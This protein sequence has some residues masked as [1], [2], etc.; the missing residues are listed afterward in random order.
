MK[1]INNLT[2]AKQTLFETFSEWAE[3][4]FSENGENVDK[5]VCRQDAFQAFYEY[6]HPKNYTPK[7]FSRSLESY[8]ESAGYILEL[9]PVELKG[10][11][12]R[13]IRKVEGRSREMIYVRTS[14]EINPEV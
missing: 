1:A 6:A 10:V 7:A 12:G 13:I 4:Y 14:D 11:Y 2:D 8:C 5:L 9:N 3:H